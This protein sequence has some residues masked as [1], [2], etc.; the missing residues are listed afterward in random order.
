M[1]RTDRTADLLL[2]L[3]RR[4]RIA[5]IRDHKVL[6]GSD[7]LPET[8][9]LLSDPTWESRPFVHLCLWQDLRELVATADTVARDGGQPF[10]AG[11]SAANV[12]HILWRLTHRA[13]DWPCRRCADRA[14][15]VAFGRMPLSDIEAAVAEDGDGL[16]HGCLTA[17]PMP[18]RPALTVFLGKGTPA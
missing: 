10:S 1:T 11:E 2:K 5:E 6:D 12:L 16:C 3:A 4:S 14:S 18:H 15:G 7:L 8:V 9:L 17:T 13:A